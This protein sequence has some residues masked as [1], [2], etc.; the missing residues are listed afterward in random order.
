[1][2]QPDFFAADAGQPP[3][4]RH[5]GTP[6]RA[7]P[8]RGDDVAGLVRRRPYRAALICR[9]WRPLPRRTT[10]PRMAYT[11]TRPVLRPDQTRL[12]EDLSGLLR[13]VAGAV[14]RRIN[15]RPDAKALARGRRTARGGPWWHHHVP[16]GRM[17]AAARDG[18]GR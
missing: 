4:T 16:C 17:P 1:M 3:S 10:L 18:T 6:W 2:Q 14:A 12:L 7:W 9:L 5:S 8:R 15:R 13:A 11:T